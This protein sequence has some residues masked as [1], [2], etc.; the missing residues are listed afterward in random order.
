MVAHAYNPCIQRQRQEFGPGLGYVV[1][2][3]FFSLPLGVN[4]DLCNLHVGF[5]VHCV[6]IICC[7]KIEAVQTF[8]QTIFKC[9]LVMAQVLVHGF[10]PVFRH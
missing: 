4:S 1:K 10:A 9:L 6:S 2:Y 7:G 8:P 3:L 5:L